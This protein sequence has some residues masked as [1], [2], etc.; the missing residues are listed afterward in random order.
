VYIQIGAENK[1]TGR[2]NE[3]AIEFT[4][5]Y[6]KKRPDFSM[7]KN[8]VLKSVRNLVLTKSEV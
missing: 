4:Q 3:M 5:K 1:A 6:T 2:E 7:L 8:K